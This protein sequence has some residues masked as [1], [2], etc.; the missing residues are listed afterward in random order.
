MASNST[1]APA[2]FR[3]SPQQER[4]WQQT[5]KGIPAT[6]Q[7][8]VRLRGECDGAKLA[9]AVTTVVSNYEILRTVLRRQ[10]GVRLPFQVIL[11]EPRFVFQSTTFH[12]ADF[13]RALETERR[14]ARGSEQESGFRVL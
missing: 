14:N 8:C 6:A 9:H 3:L 11:N 12:P 13:E 1:M 4:S 5:S 10:S 7:L 2:A